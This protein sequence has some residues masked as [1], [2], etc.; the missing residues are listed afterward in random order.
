MWMCNFTTPVVASHICTY[1]TPKEDPS[2]LLQGCHQ[3]F[4][5]RGLVLILAPHMEIEMW[6]RMVDWNNQHFTLC[7]KIAF[8]SRLFICN[9]VLNFRQATCCSISTESM[10]QIG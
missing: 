3:I 9:V 5:Q 8:R 10:I 7:N 4:T 2:F 1:R 6:Y